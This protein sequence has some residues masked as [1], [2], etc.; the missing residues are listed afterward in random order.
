[1]A[2]TNKS[3]PTNGTVKRINKKVELSKGLA[4]I[5]MDNWLIVTLILA[6]S[7]GWLHSTDIWA[8]FESDRHFSH[9]SSLERDLA[10]RTEMGL[11]Y[12]YYQTI[13]EGKFLFYFE[14]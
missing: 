4:G 9:L 12:S 10:F 11:Y 3:H 14:L 6:A 7:F 2:K 1:M 13:I 5:R 8:M